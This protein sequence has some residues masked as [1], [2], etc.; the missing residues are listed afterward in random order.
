MF[1]LHP[2]T[3]TLLILTFFLLSAIPVAGW[4]TVGKTENPAAAKLWFGGLGLNVFA[5]LLMV[6]PTIWA[7]PLTNALAHCM[8]TVTIMMMGESLRRL[9]GSTRLPPWLFFGGPICAFFV[10]FVFGVLDGREAV[11]RSAFLFFSGSLDIWLLI[12]VARLHRREAYSSVR[13]IA[14]VLLLISIASFIRS[15]GFFLADLSPYLLS[16]SGPAILGWITNLGG[17]VLLS[18]GYWSF[19][20][21]RS[22]AIELQIR[23]AKAAA[24]ARAQEAELK[25]AELRDVIRQ[26][27]EMI[28]L[29]SK[30]SV[31]NT[32]SLFASTITHEMAQYIQAL[33]LRLGTA[34]MLSRD[35]KEPLTKE[36][37]EAIR[38]TESIGS[39]VGPLRNL[40]IKNTPGVEPVMIAAE[41]VNILPIAIEEG[42][43][44]SVSISYR[45][46]NDAAE[47]AC[48]CDRALLH[49]V[50]FNLVTNSM[51]EI[52]A[53]RAEN[54]S[55]KG[56]IQIQLGTATLKEQSALE[57]V[58]LDDGPG[59]PQ[60]M[61]QDQI[62]LLKTSKPNGV[63]IGLALVKSIVQSWDGEVHIANK[64]GA[65][66]T[67][68]I[69]ACNRAV[70]V[71]DRH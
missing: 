43:Y 28:M 69:P 7:K 45:I 56:E 44:R 48:P 9:S 59:F 26:R 18:V 8:I 16:F 17:V 36:L 61:V 35:G 29:N 70:T 67:I 58:F 6:V 34:L 37:S 52:L 24:D 49:R 40:L 53:H 31:F 41:L 32:M 14:I 30:L 5:L 65:E 47:V 20:L 62:E 22:H 33:G 21:E 55:Y 66:V 12:E 2:A 3:I 15:W 19:A 25:G 71:N 23:Q 39:S 4:L 63:G 57:L 68:L 27:N 54:P 10:M 64:G 42:R 50:I 11:G 13:L 1:A 51:E 38:L 46:S 60:Q